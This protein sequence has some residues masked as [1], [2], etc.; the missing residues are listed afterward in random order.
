[1]TKL[2]LSNVIQRPHVETTGGE[3]GTHF[4]SIACRCRSFGGLG[5]F[6][7]YLHAFSVCLSP[8]SLPLQHRLGGGRAAVRHQPS[9]DRQHLLLLLAGNFQQLLPR[10]QRRLRQPSWPSAAR[11]NWWPCPCLRARPCVERVFSRP[12][13]E[14]C[15]GATA[16][17]ARKKRW[18]R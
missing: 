10:Q 6:G 5:W 18:Q 16:A 11:S 13:R 7:F 3:H 12:E 15:A 14:R 4:G 8:L 17:R 2:E 9:S 1:M